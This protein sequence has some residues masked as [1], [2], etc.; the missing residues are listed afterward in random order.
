MLIKS[1][2]NQH[3]F[4]KDDEVNLL[5]SKTQPDMTMSVRE[6]LVRFSRGIPISGSKHA[7]YEGDE[8]P[9]PD[10]RTLDLAERQQL[11]EEYA[12]LMDAAKKRETAAADKKY[13]DTVFRNLKKEYHEKLK[14]E[15][16][17]P[18]NAPL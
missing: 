9:L 18:P 13:R 1:M 11:I 3:L 10:P 6:I 14:N 2:L 16:P 17:K 5:P 7:I 4:P 8:D 12:D 15:A